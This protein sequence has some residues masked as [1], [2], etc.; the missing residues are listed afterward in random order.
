MV[1]KW[2]EFKNY[3]NDRISRPRHVNNKY[4]QW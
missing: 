2:E 1:F 3:T 4:S